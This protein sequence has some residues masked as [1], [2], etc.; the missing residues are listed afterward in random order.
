[1]SDKIK[2]ILGEDLYNEVK[3]KLG[4]KS[5][6]FLDG[7]IPKTRFDELNDKKKVSEGKLKDYEKQLEDTKALISESDEYKNKYASLET[8]FNETMAQKDIAMEN[9]TKKFLIKESLVKSG[10]KH[11]EL[12]IKE[13]D[14][15]AL[16][17]NDNKIVGISDVV[18]N[19]KTT[20]G[21]LFIE[22][23]NSSNNNDSTKQKKKEDDGEPDWENI[24]KRYI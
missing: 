11:P 24:A 6:D 3:G 7:Y 9:V 8:K 1:M 10:A 23:T 14:M 16:Q 17:I 18:N 15:T 19:L 12:L 20:Y 4:D 22:T 2:T 5:F 13:I 21:D